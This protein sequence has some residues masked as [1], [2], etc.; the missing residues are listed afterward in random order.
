MVEFIT[1][2]NQIENFNLYTL[3]YSMLGNVKPSEY[4]PPCSTNNIPTHS[5]N[6]FATFMNEKLS[7][8]KSRGVAHSFGDNGSIH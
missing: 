3:E 2:L 8:S 4:C 1:I 7:D 5:I 6:G